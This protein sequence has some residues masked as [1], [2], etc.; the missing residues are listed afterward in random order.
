MSAELNNKFEDLE[1]N[2][3]FE[4]L[5]NVAEHNPGNSDE[6][7][8]DFQARIYEEL[9]ESEY[10]PE[11]SIVTKTEFE[12]ACALAMIDRLSEENGKTI[13]FKVEIFVELCKCFRSGSPSEIYW[14]KTRNRGD[15]V[16]CV[17]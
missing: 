10:I 14:T 13:E 2:D 7:E 15:P 1:L 11:R 5:I 9:I 16:V 4:Y 3:K 8:I 12:F 17:L 6:V